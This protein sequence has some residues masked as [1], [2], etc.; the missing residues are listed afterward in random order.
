MNLVC[1]LVPIFDPTRMN[2]EKI[3]HYFCKFD[4]FCSKHLV[5]AAW[6]NPCPW[7]KL[8]FEPFSFQE[9]NIL[10]RIVMSEPDEPEEPEE[11]EEQPENDSYKET[12]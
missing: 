1:W 12:E 10:P 3:K 5:V 6:T 11:P 9:Q 2:I 8:Y 4:C 7:C